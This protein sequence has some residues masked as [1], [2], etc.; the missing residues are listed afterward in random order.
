MILQKIVLYLFIIA[1]LINTYAKAQQSDPNIQRLLTLKKQQ[2]LNQNQEYKLK[3]QINHSSHINQFEKED[4]HFEE[5]DPQPTPQPQPEPEPKPEG[6]PDEGS[7]NNPN[8]PTSIWERLWWSSQR[9]LM[10]KY[11]VLIII[12]LFVV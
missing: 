10:Y 4:I 9:N 11:T 6:K 5:G 2:D 3:K 8:P 1:S 7:P 12:L